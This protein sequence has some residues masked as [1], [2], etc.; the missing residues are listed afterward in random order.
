MSPL[1]SKSPEETRKIGS[2]FVKGLTRRPC[3][4]GL[5]GDLGSGKTVF[6]QGMAKGLGI[7]PRNYVTSPTFT[8]INE[9]K[10]LIHADLYRI[11]KPSEGAT[12]AIEEYLQGE[13]IIVVEWIE[14]MPALKMDYQ[15]GL[16]TLSGRERRITVDDRRLRS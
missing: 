14:R 7:D 2:R 5:T 1:L 15:V 11:E 8:M 4:V 6:V 16:E 13:N 9:Y 10:N 3:L 12:L